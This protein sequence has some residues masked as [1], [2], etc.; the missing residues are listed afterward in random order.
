MSTKPGQVQCGC[1]LEGSGNWRSV[2][3]TLRLPY[4]S[5]PSQG[6]QGKQSTSLSAWVGLDGWGTSLGR[7]FQAIMNFDLDTTATPPSTFF[8]FPTWQWWIPVPNNPSA[9]Q[10]VS[11]GT[12]TNAPAMNPGD[13]VRIYC[14]YV[15][16]LNGSNWGAVYFLFYND[17]EPV[18]AL[19]PVWSRNPHRTAEIPILMN[20]LFPGPPGVAGQGGSIEWIME[21][22]SVTNGPPGTIMPVFSA[23]RDSV[24]P[25]TF[26]QAIGYGQPEGVTGDPGNGFTVLWQNSDGTVSSVASVALATEAVSITYTG[27]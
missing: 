19:E 8:N 9:S 2:T 13:L 26:T 24:T 21:N 11:G 27:P 22:E 25:V 3:G 23:S 4:L 7:L 5:A 17:P 6:L 18:V 16:A 10:M 12:I 14:G 20:F 15:T 1:V